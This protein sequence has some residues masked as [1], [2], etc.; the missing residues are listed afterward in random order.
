MT[1]GHRFIRI[2]K[3]CQHYDNGCTLNGKCKYLFVFHHGFGTQRIY[4]IRYDLI[5][6]E[7]R[8]SFSNDLVDYRKTKRV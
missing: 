7:Y 2:Q 5:L 3:I 6:A 4:I 1:N 8:F